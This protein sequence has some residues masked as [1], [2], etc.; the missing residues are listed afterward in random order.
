MLFNPKQRREPRLGDTAIG[1]RWFEHPK[2]CQHFQEL[3]E[4]KVK[5]GVSPGKLAFREKISVVIN[6]FH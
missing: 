5:E 3:L 2:D 4:E 6:S 1:T